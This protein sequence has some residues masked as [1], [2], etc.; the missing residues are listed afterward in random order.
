MPLTQYGTDVIKFGA[1]TTN[2]NFVMASDLT[3]TRDGASLAV[4]QSPTVND[5]GDLRQIN[6][7]SAPTADMQIAT[8]KYVDD[9]EFILQSTTP[10]SSKKFKITVDDS[11]V[12]SAAEVTE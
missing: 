9:K 5:N 10:G 7:A 12:L 8:K 4:K 1:V 11:G 3:V 6:M 2:N